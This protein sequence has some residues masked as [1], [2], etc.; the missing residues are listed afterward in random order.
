MVP[1]LLIYGAFLLIALFCINAL[2]E[3]R[4]AKLYDIGKTDGEPVFTQKIHSDIQEGGVRLHRSS[5]VDSTGK[6]IM[7]ETATLVDNKVVK[8]HIDNFQLNV[9][10]ELEVKDGKALFQ[11]Y[12]LVD[13]VRGPL[14]KEKTRK[15]PE[16]YIFGPNTE[17]F[18]KANA[19]ALK[20][21][22]KIHSQFGVFEAQDFI[23]MNFTKVK[24]KEGEKNYH[25][26]MKPSSFFI[27][28]FLLNTSKLEVDPETFHLIRY[29]GR[30]SLRREVKG[31][32]K[33]WDAEVIYSQDTAV[34]SEEPIRGMATAPD[35]N[36]VLPKNKKHDSIK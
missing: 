11:T 21:N 36:R 7:T 1:D 22:T 19:E 24:S 26:E 32:L 25:L 2:A 8:Q 14:E 6:L 20:N 10:Y 30:T 34:E 16:S 29:I 4:I 33:P 5:I 31:K 12:K 17:G 3:D 27:S 23:G 9:S 35:S 18:L 28:A 13:G 15:L